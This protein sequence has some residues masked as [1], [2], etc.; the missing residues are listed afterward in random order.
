MLNKRFFVICGL[1]VSM[2]LA[3]CNPASSSGGGE[4]GGGGGENPPVTD[5]YQVSSEYWATNI[6]GLGYFGASG[7]ITMNLKATVGDATAQTGL[8][9]NQSGNIHFN[10]EALLDGG[11]S[12]DMY[13][14]P[15]SSGSINLYSKLNNEWQVMTMPASYAS[16]LAETYSSVIY[17]W[18]FSDF[19]YNTENHS[20]EK[21][22]DT[23]TIGNASTELK[24]IAFKFEDNKFISLTFTTV[25]GSLESKCSITGSNWGTTVVTLP[26]ISHNIDVTDVSLDKE[27][28]ELEVG[29][30]ATLV[31]TV[32][33]SDATDPTVRWSS[34]DNEVATVNNGVVSAL[35]AGSAVITATAGR[36]SA[37]CTVTVK[38]KATPIV[39]VADITL[40]KETLALEVG[41]HETLIATVLPENATD[42]TVTWRSSDNSVATVENG[43]VTAISAGTA[44]ITAAAGQKDVTCVVTVRDGQPTIIEVQ[45][46]TVSPK[47]A[48][49]KI[50][51]TVTLSATVLPENATDKTVTWRSS[52][53]KVAAV[54]QSGVVVGIGEGQATITAISG[55]KT[56]TCVV[57]VE[58]E[59]VQPETITYTFVNEDNWDVTAD[60]AKFIIWAWGGTYGDGEWVQV[61]INKS[62]AGVAFEF[63]V[64][65]GAY[66]CVILRL[67]P[68]ADVHSADFSW[69]DST[70]VWNKSENLTLDETVNHKF[71]FNSKDIEIDSH[72]FV[73]DYVKASV[74]NYEHLDTYNTAYQNSTVSFFENNYAEQVTY[75]SVTN[76][77]LVNIEI[78]YCGYV[79]ANKTS[80]QD[81][82]HG[83]D[84]YRLSFRT[85]SRYVNGLQ[86]EVDYTFDYY[87]DLNKA[88]LIAFNYA[89]DAA[90]GLITIEVHYHVDKSLTPTNYQYQPTIE[91]KWDDKAINNALNKLGVVKDNVPKI[92]GV[93]DFF[94]DTS[95]INENY[96]KIRV[97]LSAE[98]A[99]QLSNYMK[100]LM[101][102]G[103]TLIPDEDVVFISPNYEFSILFAFD[104]GEDSRPIVTL[105]V[106]KY[107]GPS[108][109]SE[110]INQYLTSLFETP[111]IA[112][113]TFEH[114][115]ALRYMQASSALLI[116]F[117]V[118][119]D[120]EAINAE[121]V[122]R[123]TEKGYEGSE[124]MGQMVYTSNN[125]EIAYLIQSQQVEESD[126]RYVLVQF[127]NKADL[128]QT[129]ATY[130]SEDVTSH[131][132]GVEND[133]LIEL[134]NSSIT[135]YIVREANYDNW[136]FAFIMVGELPVD[137][138]PNG[139]VSGYKEALLEAGYVYKNVLFKYDGEQAGIYE[140]VYV[141]PHEEIA[142]SFRA[143]KAGEAYGLEDANYIYIQIYN[144][145]DFEDVET[146]TDLSV[147][148]SGMNIDNW[149]I[150]A[151]NAKFAVWAWGGEYDEG[152]WIEVQTSIDESTQKCVISFELYRNASGFEIVRLNPN[153]DI[154]DP[155]F[156]WDDENT[157]WN[158][159]NAI[160][161]SMIEE[162]FRFSFDEVPT[163]V[164]ITVENQ[165]FAFDTGDEFAF[166]GEIRLYFENGDY[167]VIDAEDVVIDTENLDMDVPG[168]ADIRVTYDYYGIR[169][170]TFVTILIREPA[171]LVDYSLVNDDS[172][173]ILSDEA[174]FKI[175]AWGGHH[176]E[177]QWVDAEAYY[178]ENLEANMLSFSLYDD[179][180]GYV[181][182]RLSPDADVNS[183][184][185][186]W[187]DGRM[188]WN[189][190]DNFYPDPDD[191]TGVFH[192]EERPEPEKEIIYIAVEDYTSLYYIGEEFE[193]DGDVYA[194]YNDGSSELVD[195]SNVLIRGRVDTS[196]IGIYP[197]TVVYN[198]G[199]GLVFSVEIAIEV[200]ELPVERE[201]LYLDVDEEGVIAE[202][203]QIVV[204]VWGGMYGD[205]EWVVPDVSIDPETGFR[206]ISFSLYDNCEGFLFV[207]FAPEVEVFS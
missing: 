71:A 155:N 50:A 99:T 90:G 70:K 116:Y 189:Q 82:M 105:K 59:Q 136:E 156:D 56:D 171:S 25:A 162:E 106:A 120:M 88:E 63:T 166:D 60:N 158:V 4:D 108:Y 121:Y 1:A 143:Y 61:A 123:L 164:A 24:D 178:D 26:T 84:I 192:F 42:K 185:F 200:S 62:E 93:E 91:D 15:L 141:S 83:E 181:I 48:T 80:E 51:E 11:E 75:Q 94:I 28:L 137:V 161:V 23:I 187:D 19:K 30:T 17:P 65:K 134:S 52:D 100:A 12:V 172:F 92:S 167:E 205:G 101:D 186:S 39:E 152:A 165:T 195:P 193:F 140:Y 68:N 54:S 139:I 53:D 47:T 115:N 20:Y 13:I 201:C 163:P 206:T 135:S 21:A 27:T 126:Y 5:K 199:N 194:I 78:A 159:T 174:E 45:S 122:S 14:E 150:T 114:N 6:T 7:N 57:T 142:V 9:A 43:L 170:E 96:F 118:F 173:N 64:V 40:N 76:G 154:H 97:I 46:V 37:T 191:P 207:R 81:Y 188:V 196:E 151:D 179:C 34:S 112:D 87:L 111:T 197:L 89:T 177:G 38:E 184:D 49:I 2:T 119:N 36:K 109:P 204:W 31:A 153:A 138:D 149:D 102:S 85:T 113:V 104:A 183:P 73:Y 22:S 169:F 168:K 86:G 95:N 16:T 182:L 130:P 180:D 32:L 72:V 74:E 198:L 55:N 146:S 202:G 77:T 157:V 35:K 110:E 18:K 10:I 129:S 132:E 124:I 79:Q 125:S 44:V 144:L 131:L 133:T 190:S 203:E 98:G 107:E 41:A 29:N 128:P 8:I 33:P 160:D 176:D 175:W 67:N 58:K 103:F 127:L 69:D 66:G 147:Q 145:T 117:S 148:V 3:A